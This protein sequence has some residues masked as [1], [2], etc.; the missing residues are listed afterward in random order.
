MAGA[1]RLNL[2]LGGCTAAV[3]GGSSGIGAAT[4]RVLA[5]EG[6]DVALTYR[7]S[8]AGAERTA[9]EVR[10][11]GRR[12]WALPLDLTRPESARAGGTALAAEAG[13]L[14]VLVLNAG[15]NVVTPFERISVD[16]WREVLE[17]NLSGAFFTLQALAPRVR[18]GG[19]I[20]T[21]ASVAAQTGAPHHM[22]YAAAKAGLVNLTKSMAREL[23]PQV[24]VNC[25]APGITLTPMG[26]DA[27]D[28]LPEDYA[29]TSLLLQRYATPQRVA[30][31]IALVASPVTEY[32]TGAT[33]D[34]NSGRFLR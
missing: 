27:I 7:R 14:D 18:P 28:T 24:R 25:V 33:I 29:T 4:A 31:L 32:M 34:M 17:T 16:E 6:C 9:E 12:A 3:V 26:Q 5:E 23:G 2:E 20:V 21:V 22:H 19:A 10:A 1:I 13:D 8:A 30:Q 11:H 15:Y